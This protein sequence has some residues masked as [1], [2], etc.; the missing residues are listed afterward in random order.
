[1]M[2]AAIVLS[3]I[4]AAGTILSIVFLPEVKIKGKRI[5]VFFV[6]PVI[7]A[8]LIVALNVLTF[9]EAWDG[10]TG[11]MASMFHGRNS[12]N[13]VKILLLFFGMTTVSVFLDEAGVFRFLA[14]KSMKLA[15]HSRTKLF[16]ILYGVVSILTV[17]TSNDIIILTFTPFI[18]YFCK[19]ADIDP[20]PYLVTEFVAANTFSMFF[21][22][23]NPTNIYLAESFHIT[24]SGY[25][26]VMALPTIFGGLCALLVLYLLFKKQFKEEIPV[27]EVET[28]KIE[29]PYLAIF[30]AVLLIICL[31]FLIIADYVGIEMWAV[32]TCAFLLLV[33]GALVI[34]AVKKEKPTELTNV[35]KRLP[36]ELI[37]FV[38][39]MFI[40]VLSLKKTGVSQKIADV[41]GA[42]GERYDILTYGVSSTLVANLINNI[43]MSVLYSA[44]TETA[45][46]SSMTSNGTS[47]FRTT[48]I[49][50][51]LSSAMAWGMVRGNPSRIYPFLQSSFESLSLTRSITTS[52]GTRL[53]ASMKVFASLPSAVCSLMFLRNMSPVEMCGIL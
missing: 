3:V 2:T 37:P 20:V 18:C 25:L 14:T 24:F 43:P 10:L 33:I 19:N 23:G 31:V 51:T 49:S 13:P 53:P 39:S 12:V 36:Y 50:A 11:D 38:I 8:I 16:F 15:G 42:A 47:M 4:A 26:K 1:M 29:K 9:R 28:A 44:I 6:V 40:V 17:F 52:S 34:A 21:I 22:I 45:S 5:P 41:F 27:S 30:G 48:S 7:S 32:A 46:L 35:F